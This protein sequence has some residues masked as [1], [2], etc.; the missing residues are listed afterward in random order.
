MRCLATSSHPALQCAPLSGGG[1][2]VQPQ[3]VL[4][5]PARQQ[6]PL[7]GLGSGQRLLGADN[8]GLGH[9]VRR[10]VPPQSAAGCLRLRTQSVPGPQPVFISGARGSSASGGASYLAK[11][12]NAATVYFIF[13]G[14]GIDHAAN[15]WHWIR[16]LLRGAWQVRRRLRRRV[17]LPRAEVGG[18]TAEID[19]RQRAGGTHFR[20]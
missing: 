7:E 17:A 3:E 12:W 11:L 20:S 5:L 15:A 2:A 9:G 13:F 1:L 14:G 4:K 6:P 10:A 18:L 8:G 16:D 19:A